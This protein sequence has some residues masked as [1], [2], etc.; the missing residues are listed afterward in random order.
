MDMALMEETARRMV[1]RGKGILA[2]DES[3]ATIEKRFASIGLASS[4]E[5]RCAY[6][7]MLLRCGDALREYISGVILFE[8][9]LRQRTADGTPL[10]DLISG[11][12]SLAGIKVD[13]GLAP[14]EDDNSRETLTKGLEGLS[15][16]LWEYR[17]NGAVFA[18]WR[19][20]YR[21]GD[22][23]PSRRALSV[24]A[25][26]LAS[27]AK[28]CQEAGLVPIVEPEVLMDGDHDIDHCGTVTLA[29]LRAVY[30][31]LA[32][33]GVRLQATVLKP[34]M[35]TPGEDC[36]RRADSKE[37]AEK[38]LACLSAVVP[39]EVPGIAFL[40]GG[41]KDVEATENLN[42]I[43]VLKNASSD[44][45]WALTFSFGRALQAE[46]L[47][48]WGGKQENIPAAQAKFLKRARMNA[49]ASTGTWS[50]E[51]E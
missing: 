47:H 34:N 15:D 8:E 38:T 36:S 44:A 50:A 31:A 1:A 10:V 4:P 43:N 37:I 9:T 12:D 5:S 17:E 13:K 42:A 2:A 49:K 20:V 24:N 22:R 39:A 21:I 18:K 28:R 19:G 26:R 41:Q 32:R 48:A 27:Y 7:E 33:E 14:L 46:A 11:S 40:S 29:V 16:R 30:E 6:R 23:M 3:S 45:P 35:V 51:M 25:E